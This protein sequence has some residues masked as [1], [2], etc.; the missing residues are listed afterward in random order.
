MGK[1]KAKKAALNNA[2]DSAPV[3][4][5]K[6]TEDKSTVDTTL[7]NW[8]VL[9]TA[10]PQNKPKKKQSVNKAKEIERFKSIL[11]HQDFQKNGISAIK[12]HLA[13]TH[14]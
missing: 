6:A 14:E 1:R 11:K 7:D 2:V 9:K 4:S 3:D 5:N 12:A 10:V 8:N 13:G